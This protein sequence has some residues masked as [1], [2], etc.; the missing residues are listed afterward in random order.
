MSE[1]AGA[2]LSPNA[3]KVQDA[4]SALGF[5]YRVIELA[6]PTR[7]AADAARAV[8]C[9]IGQIA[10][11]LVFNGVQSGKPILVIASGANQVNEWRVGVLIKEPLEK[12]TAAFVR[13]HTGFSVGGV[14]PIG[15]VK[16]VETFI[17]ED[18]LKHQTIWAAAGT[19]NAVVSLVPA[20]LVTMTGGRV[21]KI[22]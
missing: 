12:A 15:H 18:L 21:I 14:P 5:S 1:S 7:S 16:P 19:P 6:K 20:D 3:Q 22:K 2:P 17:D 4:L 9:D 8:G 10:K 11:S 13:E